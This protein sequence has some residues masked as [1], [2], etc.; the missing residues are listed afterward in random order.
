MV[1]V[2]VKSL[3]FPDIN[4]WDGTARCGDAQ[5]GLMVD[6]GP[7]GGDTEVRIIAEKWAVTSDE[8]GVTINWPASDK[9][10]A[11][12]TGAMDMLERF[13]TDAQLNMV[14]VEN[15]IF[16]PEATIEVE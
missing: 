9:S 12:I 2:R 10:E 16:L 4:T 13:L 5:V 6:D 14:R 1:I 7:E 15:S 11:Y 8:S 3:E